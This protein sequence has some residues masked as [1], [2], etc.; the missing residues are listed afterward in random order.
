MHIL[1]IGAG[2]MIGRK[3]AAELSRTGSL[4]DKKIE[5]MTLA[6]L[7]KPPVPTGALYSIEAIAADIAVSGA[8]EELAARRADVIFHLAAIVSGEAER[9]FEKGYLINVDGTRALFEAIRLEG[10]RKKY[11]PRLVFTSSVAVYGAPLPDPI[12]DD[13]ILAPLTSYGTQKAISELL[14]ADYS[15]RGF[16]D[17]I[18]IRLPTIVI[19][20]GAP[21]AAASGFFSGI[22]REPLAGQRSVLPV[23]ETVKHWL[24]SP[25]TAV[26]LLIHAAM[27][28]TSALGARRTLNMPGVAATVSDQIAALRRVAGAEAEAL[29]D[30]KPDEAIKAIIAGWPKSFSPTLAN[31]LG[32][33]AESTVDEL[34]AVYLAD[35][36][37]KAIP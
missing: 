26:A 6:D 8:A 27:L 23:E 18:G 32:F 35:D 16:L 4:G 2:G 30:R 24:A 36:A 28:D 19:R 22:L 33:V 34:I 21:N 29:I 1:I 37:P 5:R 17:G 25:R 31:N 20:P 15:R 11:L 9:D 13:Y 10:A 7:T 12:P 14:L 3:L